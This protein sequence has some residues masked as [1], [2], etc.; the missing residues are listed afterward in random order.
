VS[1]GKQESGDGIPIEYAFTCRAPGGTGTLRKT[2]SF[3]AT[4]VL[5]S[6]LLKTQPFP[7]DPPEQPQG[8]TTVTVNV[9]MRRAARLRVVP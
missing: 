6:T 3:C 7:P 4:Y 5:S 2:I 1:C 9:E 8:A